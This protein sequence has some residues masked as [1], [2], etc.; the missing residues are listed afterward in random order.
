[1]VRNGDQQWR[2]KQKYWG[3]GGQKKIRITPLLHVFSK[4]VGG[5]L[6]IYDQVERSVHWRGVK[7]QSPGGDQGAQP[8]EAQGV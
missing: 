7:G 3:G 6:N 2:N 1:M 4:W 8:P 5:G